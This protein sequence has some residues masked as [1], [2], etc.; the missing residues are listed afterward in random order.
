[1]KDVLDVTALTLSLSF[2]SFEDIFLM[3]SRVYKIYK[4]RLLF[5]CNDVYA[6]NSVKFEV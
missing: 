4:T 3:C 2:A 5:N 1:M 6:V